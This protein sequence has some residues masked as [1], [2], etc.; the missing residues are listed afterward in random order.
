MLLG[1]I[2]IGF[3]S[4]RAP[5]NAASAG[6]VAPSVGDMAPDFEL[7]TQDGVEF[8]MADYRGRKPVYVIFWNTWCSYCIKKIPRYQKLQEQ[9]GDKI[10]IIAINTTWSDTPQELRSFKEQ[11]DISYLMAFDDGESVTD[12]YQVF[13]VPTEFIV[14][15]NG[16]I[17]Y[18]DGLPEY[19]VAHLP[20]WLVPHVPSRDNAQQAG[21]K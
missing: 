14:D 21:K 16:I 11:H 19:L 4:A 3:L 17:R 8:R 9:F 13:K 1:L 12:Q 20:D 2:A 18:R 5:A 10:Q 6:D 15:I 7:T